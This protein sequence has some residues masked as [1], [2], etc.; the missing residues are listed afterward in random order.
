MKQK[1]V[2]FLLRHPFAENQS[3]YLYSS[4]GLVLVPTMA[5]NF[6]CPYCFEKGKRAQFAK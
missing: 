6:D 1:I 3:S 2:I 5:C 4:L